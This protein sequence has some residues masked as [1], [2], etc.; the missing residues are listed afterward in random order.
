MNSSKFQAERVQIDTDVTQMQN[1]LKADTFPLGAWPSQ[2]SPSLMQQ[3]GINI[4][5][6]GKQTIF[7]VNGPPGTGKQLC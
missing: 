4:A 6:C 2:Y 5:T 7:S 1:W 3:L